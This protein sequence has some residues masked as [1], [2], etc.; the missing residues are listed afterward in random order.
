MITEGELIRLLELAD[1]ALVDDPA[2]VL[3]AA[4]YR[5]ALNA[6]STHVTLIDHEPAPTQPASGRRWPML[7]FAAAAVVLVVGVLVVVVGDNSEIEVPAAPP[8]TVPSTSVCERERCPWSPELRAQAVELPIACNRSTV[9]YCGDLAVSP[10]GTLVVFDGAAETLTWYEDEPRVVSLTPGL[11]HNVGDSELV[12]I[13]PHDIAYIGSPTQEYIVA[14]APSGAEITRVDSR[15]NSPVPA[16]RKATGLVDTASTWLVFDGAPAMPWVDLDGNPITDTRPYPTATVTDAGVVVHL[17]ERE[18]LLTEEAGTRLVPLEFL[19][20]SDGGVVMVLDESAMGDQASN[21]LE[22]SPDGSIGRYFVDRPA[23][24]LP[25][26]SLI[27]EYSTR[28]VRLRPAGFETV[29]AEVNNP[30]QLVRES[31]TS[32]A[33]VGLFRVT[34]DEPR[35]WRVTTLPEFDGLAWR[36]PISDL[37]RITDTTD[38]EPDGRIIRQQLQILELQGQMLPAAADPIQVASDIDTDIRLNRDTGTILKTTELEYG[39]QFTI[40]SKAPDATLDVLRAATTD[41][42]PD[43]LFVALPDNVPGVVS[44]LATEVTA[45]RPPKPTR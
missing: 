37:S 11:P 27:V 1:P 18:W 7:I 24:V 20:R 26:G 44:D 13:G 16:Y 40:V 39:N 2:P 6:R 32:G 35:Y 30:L 21:L 28:L 23:I 33:D 3:D 36:V 12:A 5:D 22:L 41:N 17:G 8:S 43:D 29:G 34:T 45:G 31:L 4:E 14:I 19:A 15:R 42:P 9:P 25:D 10:E 38:F